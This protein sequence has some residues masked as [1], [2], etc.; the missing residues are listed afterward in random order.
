MAQINLLAANVTIPKI[1]GPGV[2]PGTNG[3]AA[4]EKIIGQTIG[5]LTIIA[6]IYFVIQVILGGYAFISAQGDPKA[7]EA[8]RKRLT[9]GVLGV[10]IVIVAVGLG[11]LVATLF[12]I[13]NILDLNAMFTLM[14]L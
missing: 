4:M 5:V 11:S 10:V 2:D 6:I 14:G 1:T 13:T 9:D 8:A 12:G 3:T 7:I